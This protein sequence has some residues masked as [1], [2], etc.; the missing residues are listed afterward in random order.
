MTASENKTCPEVVFTC[1]AEDIESVLRWNLNSEESAV[2]TLDTSDTYP[3]TLSLL[4]TPLNSKVGTNN[5]DIQILQARQNENNADNANFLSTMKVDISA[6]QG[7][8]VTTV[9]CG[10]SGTRNTSAVV[11]DPAGGQFYLAYP[12]SYVM[13]LSPCTIARDYIFKFPGLAKNLV[14][15]S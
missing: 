4:N 3:I 1:L 5:V 9:S 14:S 8:N 6:L 10:S 11:F 7:A 13:T 15:R 12:C 2:Y